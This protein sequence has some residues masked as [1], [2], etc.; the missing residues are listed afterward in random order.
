[1]QGRHAE[2][3]RLQHGRVRMLCGMFECSSVLTMRAT[4]C[5]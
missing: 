4:D 1:M 3:S 5:T 2:E